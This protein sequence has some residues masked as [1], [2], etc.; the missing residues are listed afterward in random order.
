MGGAGRIDF[1][2]PPFANYAFQNYDVLSNTLLN[3]KIPAIANLE[4]TQVLLERY[5]G[6]LDNH[7]S[8]KLWEL[9]N[10]FV[11][12]TRAVRCILIDTPLWI[13]RSAGLISSNAE[14]KI[15]SSSLIN[16][17][18]GIITVLGSLASLLAGWDL[19]M[20]FLSRILGWLGFIDIN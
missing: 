5:I 16:K 14:S 3:I 18:I 9:I 19:L 6:A 11:W 4:A 2:R 20:A 8:K 10:P 7:T 15:K 12:L 17:I 1:Y 13:F